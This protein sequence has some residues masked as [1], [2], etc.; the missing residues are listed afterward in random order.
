VIRIPSLVRQLVFAAT[1]AGTVWFTA[2]RTK[3][4]FL[5]QAPLAGRVLAAAYLDSSTVR[6]PWL[7]L[8]EPLA[9]R[10][11]REPL[12]SL[13]LRR[14]ATVID[15]MIASVRTISRSSKF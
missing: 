13:G 10:R 15:W 12:R 5:G 7:S 4:V 8:P 2:T 9:M 1:A 14:S 6:A 3:P 11:R